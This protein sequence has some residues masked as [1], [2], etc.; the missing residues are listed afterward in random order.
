MSLD[1]TSDAGAIG[2][3]ASRSPMP[4]SGDALLEVIRATDN[5]DA[6]WDSWRDVASTV[7]VERIVAAADGMP[8]LVARDGGAALPCAR[9]L[10]E[11]ADRTGD[12]RAAATARLGLAIACSYGNAFKDALVTLDDA[13]RRAVDDAVLSA[14][15]Q[16]ARMHALARLGQ[17]DDAAHAG[18]RALEALDDER[19]RDVA[20]KAQANLGVIERM[21][22]RPERAIERFRAALATWGPDPIGRA[23]L[24]SNLAEAL[25]ELDR[26]TAA[27]EAFRA[28]LT[29]LVTAGSEQA[30]RIVEGNL[31]DL[32]ARQGR[33]KEALEHYE[34]V[35]R[36]FIAENARGDAARLQAEEADAFA[37][38]GLTQEAIVEYR[39]ALPDLEA[40]GL[41][42]EAIRARLGL[43][44]ALARSGRRDEAQRVLEEGPSRDAI[45]AAYLGRV[46]RCEGEISRMRGDL[47]GAERAF[48]AAI[49]AA[50]KQPIEQAICA[51]GLATVMLAEG[52]AGDALPHVEAAL[53]IASQRLC[54][55]L[56]A[57]LLDLKARCL[58]GVGRGDAAIATW[59][60]SLQRYETL[61]GTLQ[62]ERHRVAF[63]AS[64]AA[65]A[66][67]FLVELLRRGDR[68]SLL[69]AVAVAERVRGRS[70]LELV[71]GTADFAAIA[72]AEADDPTAAELLREAAEIR[73]EANALFSR[74]ERDPE[75]AISDTWRAHVLALEAR[76]RVVESRL[77]ATHRLSGLLASPPDAPAIERLARP[78]MA[79]V[80]YVVANGRL[81]GF[82]VVGGCA[83][84]ADLGDVVSIADA[85]ERWRFQVHRSLVST[86]S[87]PSSSRAAR[88]E[89]D[90]V[91]ASA[92]LGQLVLE[93]LWRH[94]RDVAA[95]EFVPAGPLHAASFAT[96]VVDGA[97]LIDTHEVASVPSAGL[98]ASLRATNTRPVGRTLVV[99]V[100]DDAAPAIAGEARAIAAVEP[101]STLVVGTEATV[102]RVSE[103]A[104]SADLVHLAAHGRFVPESPIHSGIRLSDRW[105]TVRD[106]LSL[107]LPGSIV[108][109]SGCDTGRVSVDGGDEV[110][111]LLR[112]FFAAGAR[113][114]VLSSWPVH[115]EAT[116]ELMTAFHQSLGTGRGGA[117]HTGRDSLAD[118]RMSSAAALRA[119]MLDVRQRR[120]RT[121]EWGAFAS[122]GDVG[123]GALGARVAGAGTVVG[124]DSRVSEIGCQS[125]GER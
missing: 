53:A 1:A 22:Q 7:V 90:L 29:A 32:L 38:T 28:A 74:I 10:V 75:A 44:R 51:A 106:A 19:H 112:G 50:S 115:D 83:H 111:G 39:S 20:A 105:F 33:L 116:V 92:A 14:R 62:A 110:T 93:P 56:E 107:R 16:M 85:V 45:P 37:Q 68:A 31:A 21:R 40:C 101:N 84:G 15:V 46:H 113:S 23:Q 63:T 123:T 87:T 8:R 30:A 57:D 59:R 25:L 95:I 58:C 114:I 52:R 67:S 86:H 104:A 99:G 96:L 65:A 82:A 12:A 18:E 71:A 88:L 79:L 98:L 80:S 3:G 66:E 61:R 41:V 43:V 77:G 4:S 118:G 24:T 11:L 64:H 2:N 55:P 48:L 81:L 70:L 26:F 122:V 5:V 121:V 60:D 94:V 6:V 124:C 119:A 108:V 100:A 9:R 76:G 17:L 103:L 109:L 54:R 35:R 13:A 125:S 102:A 89:A 47:R 78:G 91:A 27:E 36:C 97:P 49:A 69:E 117:T 73:H 72:A 34:R 120:P 42:A